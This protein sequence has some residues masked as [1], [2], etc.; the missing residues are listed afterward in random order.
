MYCHVIEKMIWHQ[1]VDASGINKFMPY[2]F[3]IIP[4]TL[5]KINACVFRLAESSECPVWCMEIVAWAVPSVRLGYITDGQWMKSRGW[6]GGF[7][8]QEVCDTRIEIPQVLNLISEFNIFILLIEHVQE[9]IT[10]S[11]HVVYT[12]GVNLPKCIMSPK[13]SL[14][15]LE[16]IIGFRGLWHCGKI[17]KS[18]IASLE[19]TIFIAYSTVACCI[20]I[21]LVWSPLS[22]CIMSLIVSQW[23]LESGGF[24]DVWS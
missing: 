11:W 5:V 24:R 17:V 15:I 21:L 4:M 6:G 2:H 23:S 19:F 22:D 8:R 7:R 3:R 20:E 9:H 12:E 14:Q 16:W 10:C 13:V 1:L 18:S